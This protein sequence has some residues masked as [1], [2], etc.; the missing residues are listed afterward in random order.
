TS[1]AHDCR[2]TVDVLGRVGIPTPPRIPADA[3]VDDQLLALLSFSE[4]FVDGA[5]NGEAQVRQ[6][7]GVAAVN[8]VD[9]NRACLTVV[10]AQ[11]V[12][13]QVVV[14]LDWALSHGGELAARRY[15]DHERP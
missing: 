9:A 2:F 13:G 6:G 11:H 7:A 10:R 4:P 3:E 12:E 8:V 15:R 1:L 14:H 5:A